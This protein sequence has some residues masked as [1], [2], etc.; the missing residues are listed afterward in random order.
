MEAGYTLELSIEAVHLCGKLG[1][2]MDYLDAKD[3]SD[4]DEDNSVPGEQLFKVKTLED[5][6]K[7]MLDLLFCNIHNI[8]S[9]N[10]P[11]TGLKMINQSS[12]NM[13]MKMQHVT[14]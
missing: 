5:N 13:W 12:E 7:E 3:I 8:I 4:D 14:T 1:P 9:M 11:F 6:K 2:A 10:I